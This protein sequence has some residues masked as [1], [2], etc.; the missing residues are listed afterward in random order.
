VLL[1][2]EDGVLSWG[3]FAVGDPQEREG[4]E[5]ASGSRDGAAR[6]SSGIAEGFSD[7]A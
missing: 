7:R 4:R 1:H 2:I 5:P 3:T 6:G